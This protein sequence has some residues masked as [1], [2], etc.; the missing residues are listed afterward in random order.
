MFRVIRG[1]FHINLRVLET[2]RL[3]GARSPLEDCR[4]RV[5]SLV[6]TNHLA[7]QTPDTRT[8]VSVLERLRRRLVHWDLDMDNLVHRHLYKGSDRHDGTGLRVAVAPANT[9]SSEA[10]G[11]RQDGPPLEQL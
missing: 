4:Q 10:C 7:H 2:R 5:G 8:P 11:Q 1:K 6:Q 9:R 3:S